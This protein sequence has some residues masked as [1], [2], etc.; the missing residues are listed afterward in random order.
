M[1]S[2]TGATR[3]TT[4]ARGRS[5]R[6]AMFGQLLRSRSDEVLAGALDDSSVMTVN[7]ELMGQW[8]TNVDM[9]H[10]RPAVHAHD[11]AAE[12]TPRP[13]W[14]LY[15]YPKVEIN[16]SFFRIPDTTFFRSTD[17]FSDGHR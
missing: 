14:K 16:Q 5:S 2:A 9:R 3:A 15:R 12:R 8:R 10:Q 13:V 1:K 6:Q 7:M 4:R 11:A 17:H